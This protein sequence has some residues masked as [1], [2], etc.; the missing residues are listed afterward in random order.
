MVAV[1]YLEQNGIAH[2]DI[3]PDNIGIAKTQGGRYTLVLF[4]FSLSRTPVDNIQAGT[5]PYLD[6]FLPLRRR[7]DVQA[8]RFAVA[9]TLY[10]MLTGSLPTWG[11]GRSD[12]AALGDGAEATL[13]ADRFDPALRDGLVAFFTKAFRR[14]ARARF[15]NAED[16][17]RAWRHVFEAARPTVT[18]EGEN[19]LAS[20]ARRA[21]ARTP[22]A[23]FGFSIEALDVLSRMGINDTRQLLAVSRIRFHHMSAVGDRIRQEIRR[24]AKELARIRSD[25][26]PGAATIHPDGAAPSVDRLAEQLLP[27]RP[28]GDDRQDDRLIAVYLGLEQPENDARAAG[29]SFWLSP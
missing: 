10:E 7:W 5:R 8:E 18:D 4:D 14:D 9:V 22:V 17:S 1:D 29:Q 25:L 24:T 15:D 20:A 23:E 26:V 21:T 28:A 6:P 11:D 27:K 16:M 19:T 13:E 12:P 2:R 3:K